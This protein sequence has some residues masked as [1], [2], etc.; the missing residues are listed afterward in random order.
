MPAL[1]PLLPVPDG[2]GGIG[3]EKRSE[4]G[5]EPELSDEELDV[6]E[7]GAEELESELDEELDG[8]EGGGL[9]SM[10]TKNRSL[11]RLRVTQ[12]E[13]QANKPSQTRNRQRRLN[14]DITETIGQS[15]GGNSRIRPTISGSDMV[16]GSFIDAHA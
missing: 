7:L 5:E 4:D 1:D 8:V 13:K 16:V 10:G 9:L 12:I 14:T 2:C 11:A 6:P 3:T 15:G